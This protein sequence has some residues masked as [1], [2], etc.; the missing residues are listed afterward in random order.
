V[1]SVSV[2]A[3]QPTPTVLHI[4]ATLPDGTHAA[5]V[6]GNPTAF[7]LSDGDYGILNASSLQPIPKEVAPTNAPAA[8]SPAP[9]T[10][11]SAAKSPA[12][13]TNAAVGAR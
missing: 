2:L 5:Q 1:L 3:D 7:A 10:N 11:A 8:T 4:G 9:G 12:S 13:R 6:E